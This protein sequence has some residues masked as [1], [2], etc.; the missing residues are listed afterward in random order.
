MNIT[1]LIEYIEQNFRKTLYRIDYEILDDISKQ[2]FSEEQ[3]K[4][5]V[6]IC[7]Q[8]NTDSVKYLQR[9]IQN[10]K[11]EETKKP[12]WYEIQDEIKAVPLSAEERKEME[13]LLKP[14]N[15]RTNYP[16]IY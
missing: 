13:E 14:F 9:V 8:N 12:S 15:P 3:I 1:K 11:T 2:N 7:K 6:E 10:T 16:I 4:N 5:A